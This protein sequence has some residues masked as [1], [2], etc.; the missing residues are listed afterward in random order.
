[1]IIWFQEQIKHVNFGIILSALCCFHVAGSLLTRQ[2]WYVIYVEIPIETSLLNISHSET[3]CSLDMSSWAM[4][5]T[6]QSPTLHKEIIDIELKWVA[7][8]V[9]A[10]VHNS[11]F[12]CGSFVSCIIAVRHWSL[13]N[14]GTPL[15]AG[16]YYMACVQLPK[17]TIKYIPAD[18]PTQMEY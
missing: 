18:C 17:K 8:Y 4:P 10:V 15:D 1:M 13:G 12:C 9:Q 14:R 2:I 5:M 3:R 16:S 11:D 6:I 7:C